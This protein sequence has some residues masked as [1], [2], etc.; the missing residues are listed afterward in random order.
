VK[1]LVVIGVVIAA[2]TAGGVGARTSSSLEFR[3]LLQGRFD[4]VACPAG[5]A[6]TT[7]CYRN[8]LDGP[9]PGLGIV[10]IR[11][12]LFVEN[13]DTDC[14]TWRADSAI[15]DARGEIQIV[16][17]SS[18]CIP[19]GPSGAMGFTVTGGSG[20]Y[21]GA[22]G[23]GRLETRGSASGAGS[24]TTRSTITGTLV[25]P[26]HEFDLTSPVLTGAR[27]KTVKA[28]R[29]AKRVRVRFTITGRDDVDGSTPVVCEPRSGSRFKLGRTRVKCSATDASA[30]T[31]TARFWV[32]VRARS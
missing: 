30:N 12:T 3:G 23:S 22:S 5:T 16:A 4:N 20:A 6:P 27:S 15:T 8:E 10:S 7:S 32:T 21:T 19:Y 18:A 26:G 24:G 25:A 13:A 28:P 1:R 29:K 14:A 31:A 9:V 17:R 11:H 2:V